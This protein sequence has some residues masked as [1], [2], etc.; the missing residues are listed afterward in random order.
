MTA[1]GCAGIP[2]VRAAFAHMSKRRPSCCVRAFSPPNV[3]SRT[4]PA[5]GTHGPRMPAVSIVAVNSPSLRPEGV[6]GIVEPTA[7]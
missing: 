2:V 5:T 7:T 3:T 1:C 4:S 6:R